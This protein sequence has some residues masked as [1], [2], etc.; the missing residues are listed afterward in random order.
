M[1][2]LPQQRF[3]GPQMLTVP[4]RLRNPHYTYKPKPSS[5]PGLCSIYFFCPGPILP[6]LTAWIQCKREREMKM[7]VYLQLPYFWKL[8]S[9]NCCQNLS[10]FN[11]FS[12][13]FCSL[14][15]S[16]SVMTKY[17]FYIFPSVNTRISVH[18]NKRLS[19]F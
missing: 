15:S 3:I 14:L 7:G 6:F 12:H 8:L 13:C 2:G 1:D 5:L 10:A 11:P 4:A 19:G 9:C 17:H 16:S 18:S